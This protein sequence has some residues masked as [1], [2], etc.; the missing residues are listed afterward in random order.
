MKSAK[1]ENIFK[2]WD[3]SESEA[4]HTLKKIPVFKNLSHKDFNE[5]ENMMHHRDLIRELELLN[6]LVVN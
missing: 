4:V 3:N 6:K 1:W 2:G 5:L